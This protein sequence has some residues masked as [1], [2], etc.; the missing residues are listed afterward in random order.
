MGFTHLQIKRNPLTRG[1]HP[2][3][4]VLSALCPQLDL[5]LHFRCSKTWPY[6]SPAPQTQN[7]T[8]IANSVKALSSAIKSSFQNNTKNLLV[9]FSTIKQAVLKV[10]GEKQNLY[11]S[12]PY[13]LFVRSVPYMLQNLLKGSK[14]VF[15]CLRYYLQYPAK[16]NFIMSIKTIEL[17]SFS[18]QT[19][20]HQ[21]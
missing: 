20:I 18:P 13:L 16:N 1:Y 11:I 10:L 6:C 7:S 2:Q 3:N 21:I 14:N 15:N 17:F 12:P 9:V 19:K 8:D 5:F 4:H